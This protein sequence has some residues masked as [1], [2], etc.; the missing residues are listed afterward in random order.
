VGVV[1][2]P[3]GYQPEALDGVLSRLRPLGPPTRVGGLYVFPLR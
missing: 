2:D 3:R 1:V